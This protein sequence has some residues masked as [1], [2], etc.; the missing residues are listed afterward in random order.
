MRLLGGHAFY[1]LNHFDTLHRTLPQGSL[2]AF[3]A[4]P[5]QD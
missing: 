3:A 4:D 2:G 5:E 1:C